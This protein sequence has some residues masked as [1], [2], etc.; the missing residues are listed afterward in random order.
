MPFV[1]FD[2]SWLGCGAVVEQRL[3]NKYAFPSLG[4]T[5]SNECFQMVDVFSL[6]PSQEN[7]NPLSCLCQPAIASF[8]YRDCRSTHLN[9]FTSTLIHF[10]KLLACFVFDDWGC[11]RDV[12]LP[13][14]L[15]RGL[16]F[17]SSNGEL[18]VA[19]GLL[20]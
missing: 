5:T 12:I 18:T 16:G 3:Q 6:G 19:V 17:S 14:G 1:L 10:P 13:G 15:L 20:I 8:K 7:L 4:S 2:L 11:V 9:P